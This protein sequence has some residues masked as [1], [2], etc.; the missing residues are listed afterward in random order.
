MKY[1]YRNETES[2][3]HLMFEKAFLFTFCIK[4]IQWKNQI[5]LLATFGGS[6]EKKT[7]L[8]ENYYNARAIYINKVI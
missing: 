3:R 8:S 4:F 2:V 5:K 6:Q 1:S 7:I